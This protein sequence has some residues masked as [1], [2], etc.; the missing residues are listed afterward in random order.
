MFN[1]IGFIKTSSIIQNIS[2]VN[3]FKASLNDS[4]NM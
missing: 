1:C 2:N 4:Q 3:G